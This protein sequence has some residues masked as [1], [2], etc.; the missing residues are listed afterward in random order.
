MPEIDTSFLFDQEDL[1]PQMEGF[2]TLDEE[3]ILEEVDNSD[4]YAV[5][6]VTAKELLKGYSLALALDPSQNGSGFALVD[7]RTNF[8][9]ALASASLTY[10]DKDNDPLRYFNM[11]REYAADVLA[12]IREETKEETPHFDLIIIEDTLLRHDPQIFKRLV[13]INN[14]IDYLIGTQQIKTDKFIRVN[15][16]AWK[17]ELRSYKLGKKYKNDK[18]DIEESLL[19]LELDYALANSEQTK[20]WKDR[21]NYQDK[22]DAIGMLIAGVTLKDVDTGKKTRKRRKK[23]KTSVTLKAPLNEQGYTQIHLKHAAAH[24]EETLKNIQQEEGPIK[25]FIPFT[26]LG[27]WGIKHKAYVPEGFTQAYLLI[28]EADK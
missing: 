20:A 14:V 10:S 27:T 12:F 17:K 11:Q 9:L 7:N 1:V 13:M 6:K 5:K 21:N 23:L 3:V 8:K 24:I 16:E 19:L 15:N 2:L 4:I 25:Y 26:S 22:L 28:E 18:L